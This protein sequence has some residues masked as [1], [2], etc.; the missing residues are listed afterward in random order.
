MTESR[1]DLRRR[2]GAER[3]TRIDNVRAA[4]KL[5]AAGMSPREVAEQLDV[6][7]QQVDRMLRAAELVGVEVTPAELI[8]KAWLSGSPREALVEAL[9]G[10]TYT[11]GTFAPLPAAERIPGSWDDVVF[12]YYKGRL[13]GDEF[14]RVV[15]AVQPPPQV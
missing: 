11:F 2:R 14:E 6:T 8:L 3:V 9:C 5:S 7:E 13:S 1:E 4:V 12:G 15:E 10:W